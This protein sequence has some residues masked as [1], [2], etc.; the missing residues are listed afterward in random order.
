[1]LVLLKTWTVC[2]STEKAGLVGAIKGTDHEHASR[3]FVIGPH[4]FL[5]IVSKPQALGSVRP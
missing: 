3:L 1:M 5:V 2:P 4:A